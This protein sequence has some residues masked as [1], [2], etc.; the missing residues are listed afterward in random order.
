MNKTT[1]HLKRAIK[2]EVWRFPKAACTG[3]ADRY[4][5]KTQTLVGFQTD[6]ADDNIDLDVRQAYRDWSNESYDVV[7]VV[8]I[9]SLR[10][11]RHNIDAIEEEDGEA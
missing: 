2:L 1:V 9:K 4:I 5:M 7:D 3:A 6:D 8:G 10:I 11:S